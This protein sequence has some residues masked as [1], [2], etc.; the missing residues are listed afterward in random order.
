MQKYYFAWGQ[1][2]RAEHILGGGGERYERMGEIGGSASD[3]LCQKA[4]GSV[5]CW[6][7]HK[8]VD[9]TA[10]STVS[11]S[12]TVSLFTFQQSQLF[13]FFSFLNF[14]YFLRQAQ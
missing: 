8:H 4:Q 3:P 1:A 10:R 13:F 7:V 12:S 5:G 9:A 6:F 2:E 14:L 11:T